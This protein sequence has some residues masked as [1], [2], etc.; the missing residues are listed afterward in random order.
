MKQT[1]LGSAVSRCL[2]RL[3]NGLAVALVTLVIAGTAYAGGGGGSPDDPVPEI[4]TGVLGSAVALLSGS[5]LLLRDR[6]R[7]K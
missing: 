5:M 2:R 7:T 1:W 6:F 3:R 4:N